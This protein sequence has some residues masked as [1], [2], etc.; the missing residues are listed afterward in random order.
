MIGK[1]DVMIKYACIAMLVLASAGC[2]VNK[3]HEYPPWCEAV[4]ME[5]IEAVKYHVSHG[6]DLNAEVQYYTLRAPPLHLAVLFGREISAL[7]LLDHVADINGKDHRGQTPLHMAVL[8]DSLGMADILIKRGADVNVKTNA[9]RTLLD[10]AKHMKS[11]R[12]IEL[13]R[14]NGTKENNGKVKPWK[15]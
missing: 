10:Y 14:K 2:A 15:Q 3:Q 9:G 6:A 12:M 5:N 1:G 11:S 4:M 13:L 8:S 7:F